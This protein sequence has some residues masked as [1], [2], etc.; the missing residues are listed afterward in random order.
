MYFLSVSA[1]NINFE[2]I[3][4]PDG[5]FQI[6]FIRLIYNDVNIGIGIVIAHDVGCDTAMAYAVYT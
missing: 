3:R 5:I 2:V 6:D 4:L 1:K